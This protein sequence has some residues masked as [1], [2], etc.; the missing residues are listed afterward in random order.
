MHPTYPKHFDTQLDTTCG[1]LSIIT[2]YLL[3]AHLYIDNHILKTSVTSLRKHT[4][5]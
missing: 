2:V 4:F 1:L 3:L 5:S